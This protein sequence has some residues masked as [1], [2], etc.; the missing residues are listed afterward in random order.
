MNFRDREL[1]EQTNKALNDHLFLYFILAL[2]IVC[3]TFER[4]PKCHKMIKT[5]SHLYV[6]YDEFPKSTLS[7][8]LK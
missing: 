8:C 6:V 5:N 1:S 2:L 3:P 4:A 7:A